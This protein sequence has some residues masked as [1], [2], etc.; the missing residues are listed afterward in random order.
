MMDGVLYT[1]I[2]KFS[3]NNKAQYSVHKSTERNCT[4]NCFR[5]KAC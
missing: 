3:S 4:D 5:E 1:F 2:V